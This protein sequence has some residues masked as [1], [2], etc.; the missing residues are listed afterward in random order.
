V[1]L[2]IVSPSPSSAVALAPTGNGL[3]L[4]GSY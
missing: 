1:V 4:S 2:F 3:L